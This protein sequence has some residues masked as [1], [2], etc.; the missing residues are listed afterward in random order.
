MRPGQWFGVWLAAALAAA[1]APALAQPT[2]APVQPTPPPAFSLDLTE[3]PAQQVTLA[4]AAPGSVPIRII[5]S[6]GPASGVMLDLGDFRNDQGVT[7]AV[8]FTVGAD[9]GTGVTHLDNVPFTQPLLPINLHVPAFPAGGTFGGTLIL[10]TPTATPG[11]Q[12]TT[13]WRF[14]LSS[15][16]DVRPATLV[17]DQN[18]ATLSAARPWCL[19]FVPAWCIGGQT[20]TVTVHAF[21]KSGS[22]PLNGVTARLDTGLVAPGAGFD[23]GKSIS[24]SYNGTPDTG[25]FT[26]PSARARDIAPGGQ[27]T[28][29]LAFHD[30]PAG[31]YTLPL[32][33]VAADSTTDNAQLLTV[34]LKLRNNAL[35]AVLVLILAAIMSFLA[36]RVVGMLRQRAVFLQQLADLRPIWLADE[37]PILPVIWLRATLRQTEALSRRHWL[38]GQDQISARLTAASATLGI[39]AQVRQVRQ[40]IA[41]NIPDA[42]VRRRAEWALGRITRQ[43]G[44]GPLA[45]ADVTRLSSLLSALAGWMSNAAQQES[46]YWADLRPS[47]VARC[48][49]VQ[50]GDLPAAARA[51]AT[52]LLAVLQKALQTDPPDLGA[53]N[54]TEAA[55]ARLSIMWELRDH[56]APLA[57][58][59][60]LPNWPDAQIEQVYRVVDDFWWSTLVGLSAADLLIESPA[61]D[62]VQAFDPI[63]FRVRATDSA[64]AGCYLFGNKLTWHWTIELRNTPPKWAFWR[65]SHTVPLT[66]ISSE[67]RIAQYSPEPGQFTARVSVAYQGHAGPPVGSAPPVAIRRAESFRI[68]NFFATADLLSSGL[69]LAASVVSGVALYA[70]ADGFGSLKDYL[71]L[72]TWGA[73]LDQG[74]NFL[75]SLAVYSSA[76]PPPATPQK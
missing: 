39:L 74:K 19:W 29:T 32:R 60:A 56:P 44:A 58:L 31:V 2:P 10:S 49:E 17:L 61:G 52:D 3:T 36:T 43:I 4:V 46:C 1:G 48:A 67:P 14:N 5:R 59:L 9:T 11:V 75:Q 71:A 38:S 40:Q 41:A 45:D 55:Y 68:W 16:A 72:F 35:G 27:A 76:T 66:A 30:L 64:L 13:S 8:T 54:A 28:I 18:T 20:P 50:P 62:P 37:P 34:S 70:L 57:A 73:S 6:G 26:A 65:A 33:F 7:L 42:Q 12:Q 22:F 24:A 53:K 25:L 51:S 63:T 15:A 69:A 21:D 23:P 47:I